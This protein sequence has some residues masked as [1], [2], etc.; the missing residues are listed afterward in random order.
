MIFRNYNDF[1]IIDLIK[2]GNEE[3]FQLMVNK[4]R[5]LIAKMI[6]KFN[7]VYDY[8]DCYQ[9]ALMLLYKSIIKF[10][11][12]YNKTFTRFFELNLTNYLISY[13]NRNNNYFSFIQESL[14]SNNHQVVSEAMNVVYLDQDLIDTFQQLS[15]FEKM[16]FQLKITQQLSVK[17]IA[18]E[19]ETN[20]KR[21][22]NAM[23][24]IKKKIKMYLI[25]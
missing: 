18:K 20:E 16:V 19:L 5:Y 9:E 14:S 7:L 8:D 3:A 11:E 4:Y 23:E 21:I 22:Y 6:K 24:R 15:S 10:D 12:S 25:Q 17:E 13:K 2:Q 1:E